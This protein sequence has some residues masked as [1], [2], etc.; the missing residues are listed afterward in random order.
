MPATT[1]PHQ[2]RVRAA[3]AQPKLV[4][5]HASFLKKAPNVRSMTANITMETKKVTPERIPII[6]D[7]AYI[8]MRGKE[9]TEDATARTA[10]MIIRILIAV[11]NVTISSHLSG[12]DSV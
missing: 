3:M 11:R 9:K 5:K 8:C 1:L 7:I 6:H 12:S 10:P 4:E 2:T